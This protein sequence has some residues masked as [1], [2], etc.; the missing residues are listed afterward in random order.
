MNIYELWYL[1]RDRS[2]PRFNLLLTANYTHQKEIFKKL[3]QKET[4]RKLFFLLTVHGKERK[5]TLVL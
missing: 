5:C 4:L 2:G 3:L 1:R